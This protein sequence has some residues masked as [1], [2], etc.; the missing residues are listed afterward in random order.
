MLHA[1]FALLAAPAVLAGIKALDRKTAPTGPDPASIDGLIHWLERKNPE[2]T[3]LWELP[4]CCLFGQYGQAMGWG[5]IN[6]AYSAAVKALGGTPR[7][8]FSAQGTI[9]DAEPFGRLA[10]TQPHTFG[11]A[12]ER[13]RAWK[14]AH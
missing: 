10:H 1:L 12:L 3:Y 11:G 13:A 9:A 2:E 6:T 8:P 7:S 4:Q 14:A 5:N